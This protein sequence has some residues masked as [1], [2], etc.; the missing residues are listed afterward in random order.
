MGWLWACRVACCIG[1]HGRVPQLS[2]LGTRDSRHLRFW[3]VGCRAFGFRAYGRPLSGLE[4]ISSRPKTRFYLLRLLY[5]PPPPMLPLRVT[6]HT[7]L[8]EEPSFGFAVVVFGLRL[9]LP[10]FGGLRLRGT[11]S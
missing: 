7:A 4:G 1:F 11:A 6:L 8:V 10:G 9:R 5:Y 2:A 3:R